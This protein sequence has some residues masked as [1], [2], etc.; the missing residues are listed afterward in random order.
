M[1][2]GVG[3]GG[4]GVFRTPMWWYQIMIDHNKDYR[5]VIYIASYPNLIPCSSYLT[6]YQPMTAIAVM[7]F[8]NSP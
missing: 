6:L 2:W 7:T 1:G 3:V 5:Q 4:E 8:V